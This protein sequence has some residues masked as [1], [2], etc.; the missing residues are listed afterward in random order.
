MKT[1][2]AKIALL[3][4]TTIVAVVAL[5]TITMIYTFSAAPS[6]KAYQFE[7]LIA[8]PQMRSVLVVKVGFQ[9]FPS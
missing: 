4:V 2:R 1:L 9:E 7:G 8:D 5:I 6:S 3:L